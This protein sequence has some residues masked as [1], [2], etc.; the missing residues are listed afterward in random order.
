MFGKLT[1]LYID[2][3]EARKE[4]KIVELTERASMLSQNKE[5][6]LVLLYNEGFVN[7]R[8]TGRSITEI[9]SEVQSFV[10]T[11]INVVVLP[12][13]YFIADG[14]HQNMVVRRESSFKL[15]P[16]DNEKRTLQTSC[17]NATLEIPREMNYFDG[18]RMTHPD[19]VR[20]LEKAEFKDPMTVQAGVWAISD[21]FTAFDIK[22]RL[23]SVDDYG[24]YSQSISDDH[25]EEAR[26]ILDELRIPHRLYN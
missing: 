2:W 22:N 26:G 18:V 3:K 23:S 6:D 5:H 9:E 12:G 10:R 11:V 1:D 25:I 20:F 15:Y 14:N 19:L 4:R 13:T 8:A 21:D 16:M 24:N 17:I 7:A